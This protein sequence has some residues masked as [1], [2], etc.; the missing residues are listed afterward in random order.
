[1]VSF[2]GIRPPVGGYPA[3]VYAHCVECGFFFYRGMPRTHL[4]GCPAETDP[5]A[6]RRHQLSEFGRALLA[7]FEPAEVNRG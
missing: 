3:N 5:R 6:I 4:S 7:L 1:V 2:R